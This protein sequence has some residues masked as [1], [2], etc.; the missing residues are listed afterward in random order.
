MK[1]RA[2][3]A[4]I[5]TDTEENS[6]FNTSQAYFLT[7]KIMKITKDPRIPRVTSE[8]PRVHNNNEIIGKSRSLVKSRMAVV[9][10]LS[11][12]IGCAHLN[13]PVEPVNSVEQICS[14]YPRWFA[15]MPPKERE[16][17][18]M[19]TFKEKM[20]EILP[21]EFE[22]GREYVANF[23]VEGMVFEAKFII[24]PEPGGM[25]IALRISS[26]DGMWNFVDQ[27]HIQQAPCKEAKKYSI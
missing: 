3:C 20:P 23:T 24:V 12:S 8:S 5:V 10:A 22:P 25:A 17:K 21:K 19:E 1:F 2:I 16:K 9:L 6:V 26:W 18:I 27:V 11:A 15:E 13:K 7:F 14:S 4:I